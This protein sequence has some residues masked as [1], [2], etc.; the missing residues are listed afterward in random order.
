[1]E[2]YG[3]LHA[4][5][6]EL[7]AMCR[8]QNLTLAVAESLTGG[9]IGATLS[10]VPGASAVFKGGVICYSAHIKHKVLGV[11]EHVLTVD[12]VVSEACACEMARGVRQLCEAD[13]AVA[14]TGE[15]GPIAADSSV[16]IG[17]VCVAVATEAMFESRTVTLDGDRD[18]VRRKTVAVTL[19]L[20]SETLLSPPRASV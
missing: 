19:A 7:L 12:G 8:A 16:P 10:A 4:E 13:I 11:S 3:E 18:M 20:L 6:N 15:A 5:V 9:L 14:V 17:T 1:M 2:A